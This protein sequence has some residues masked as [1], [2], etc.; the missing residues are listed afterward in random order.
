MENPMGWGPVE[1]TIHEA[2]LMWE[3][4]RERQMVG[5]SMEMQ[6]ANALRDA[7]LVHDPSK[8]T[9]LVHKDFLDATI[10]K[11]EARE[12]ALRDWISSREGAETFLREWVK[13]YFGEDACDAVTAV[14]RAL[15]ALLGEDSV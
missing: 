10:K 1:K 2:R 15:C 11:F 3:H 14:Q 12:T 7:G 6:I 8:R 4:G 5:F 9:A 13:P